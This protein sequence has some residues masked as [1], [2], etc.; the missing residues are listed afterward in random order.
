[1]RVALGAAVLLTIVS[2]LA[3]GQTVGRPAVTIGRDG[4]SYTVAAEFTVPQPVSTVLEVLSDFEGIPRFMPDIKKSIVH[5]RTETRTVVEQEAVSRVML[6][7]KRVY[8]M[9]EVHRDHD[10]LRF[11]DIS[12]RSF[13][14]YEGTW[15]VKHQDGQTVVVYRLAADPSFSV[16][17][18]LIRRLLE[19]DAH[20]TIDRLR[21][22]ISRRGSRGADEQPP[23]PEPLASSRA[24]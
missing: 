8:L 15:Q 17:G 9:L 13:R 18:F 22:E 14:R 10:T 6:F 4:T 3:H 16:P 2:G 5:E 24:G 12:Q 21:G 23:R 7:S 20:E 11:R 1:V 19:G